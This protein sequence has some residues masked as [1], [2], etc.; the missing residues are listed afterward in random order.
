M[1]FFLGLLT[2]KFPLAAAAGVEQTI[3]GI[4]DISRSFFQTRVV[5]V[6]SYPQGTKYLQKCS[7]SSFRALH[8]SSLALVLWWQLS[9]SSLEQSPWL[10]PHHDDASEAMPRL[11]LVIDQG[12]QAWIQDAE[13]VFHEPP[14]CSSWVKLSITYII[15]FCF[16]KVFLS[17]CRINI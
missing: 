14:V 3:P 11:R 1:P 16:H 13:A 17:I 12:Q 2:C 7:Y 5:L 15:W 9:P 8:S 4:R 10:C 6:H